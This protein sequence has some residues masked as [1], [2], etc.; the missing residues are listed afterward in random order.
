MQA[1]QREA[2]PCLAPQAQ[3]GA[4]GMPAPLPAAP[5]PVLAPVMAAGPCRLAVSNLHPSITEADLQPIFAPFGALD[6]VSLQ[7]DPLGR[8]AGV[9]FVQ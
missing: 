9:A 4:G 2:P 8:S 3:L 7:R 5:L 6:F 1:G